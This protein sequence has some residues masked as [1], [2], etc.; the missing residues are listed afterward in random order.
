[1]NRCIII[2]PLY[3]GEERAWLTPEE[4]D[5]LLCA[6][7][8]YAAAAAAGLTPDLTIGDFDS[9]SRSRT[10]GPVL[11]LPTHKDDTDLL[12]CLKEGRRRGYRSFRLA[13]CIGGRL[14]HTLAAVQCLADC[15]LRGEEAW[16][17]DAGTRMTV[18]APGAYTLH[19]LGERKLSLLAFTEEV[20]GVCLSGTEWPLEDAVLTNR[21]PLGISNEFRGDAAQ[22]SFAAGLL[23]VCLSQ[24]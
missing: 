12:A 2:A 6:D 13:G 14:D 19:P 22:L 3:R 1:M 15:A 4:G 16:M 10:A 20:T 8:G 18:L 11:A 7:G 17:A 5:L 23:M 9:M 21:Y 24:D